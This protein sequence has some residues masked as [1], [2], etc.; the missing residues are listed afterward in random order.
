VCVS[1]NALADTIGVGILCLFGVSQ[2]VNDI[3]G[4]CKM[5]TFEGQVV[6]SG[7]RGVVG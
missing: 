2:V 6:F 3:T 4:C 1:N 5:R 7:T